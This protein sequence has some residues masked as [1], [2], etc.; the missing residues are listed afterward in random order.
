MTSVFV[1]GTSTQDRLDAMTQTTTVGPMRRVSNDASEHADSDGDG[2]G[3]N[4][5]LS[6]LGNAVLYFSNDSTA[7]S[8]QDY[9]FGSAPDMYLIA[10]LDLACDGTYESSKISQTVER[11]QRYDEQ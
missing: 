10:E 4:A 11:L 3:N 2:A 5:D 9:D 6:N 8:S 1:A 7:S